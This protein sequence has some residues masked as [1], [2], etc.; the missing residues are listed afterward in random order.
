MQQ[1]DHK[2]TIST[3]AVYPN[4]NSNYVNIGVEY[5]YRSLVYLRGG[6]AHLFLPNNYGQ[7]HLRAGIGVELSDKIQFD[8]AY[9]ERGDLGSVHTLGVSV[10]F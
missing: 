6:Y 4:N 5:G 8:F 3:D 10:K 1:L 7:G 2:L 9:S